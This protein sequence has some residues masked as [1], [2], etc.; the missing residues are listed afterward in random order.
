MEVHIC[1]PMSDKKTEELII[2]IK[3]DP[4]MFQLRNQILEGWPEIRENVPECIQKYWTYRDEFACIEE[5]LFRG[6]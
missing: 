4:E 6:D 2:S 3:E 5:I 1:V